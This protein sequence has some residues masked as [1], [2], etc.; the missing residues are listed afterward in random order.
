MRI[1]VIP[2]FA[3]SSLYG[4]ITLV[5]LNYL[6]IARGH[7]QEMKLAPDG[8][9]PDDEEGKTLTIGKGILTG[10]QPTKPNSPTPQPE[11]RD[12]FVLGYYGNLMTYLYRHTA[13]T[14][15]VI[16][17]Y[18]YDWRIRNGPEAD[19]LVLSIVQNV[20]EEDPCCLIAHSN[21][22]LIARWA[23]WRL[24]Q[25]GLQRLVKRII[26]LGTPHFGAYAYFR[27]IA[28]GL[29]SVGYKLFSMNNWTFGS[30]PF[31]KR[32]IIG[33]KV[34][35]PETRRTV[36]SWPGVYELGPVPGTP[37]TEGD[38]NVGGYLNAASYPA[39]FGAQKIA[40][41]YIRNVWHPFLKDLT[42]LPPKSVMITCFGTGFD[43][44]FHL[45]G[46]AAFYESTGYSESPDGDGTVHRLS[47]SLDGYYSPWFSSAHGD[48]P[49]A[50]IQGDRLWSLIKDDVPVPVPPPQ[51]GPAAPLTP[52]LLGRT[53]YP[54]DARILAMLPTVYASNAG[55]NDP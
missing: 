45:N 24:F 44:P 17:P 47:A 28:C 5:W 50:V 41:T 27:E 48:L 55:P 52:M 35:L 22:G 16:H 34:S 3:G 11:P 49:D 8:I 46:K 32:I 37:L 20:K 10:P 19:R 38:P 1:Y 4:P 9:N 43:T 12:G 29:S 2:G 40:L 13:N 26:T 21:G 7:F 39:N 54:P 25:M 42:L 33:N 30:L 15:D 36:L 18:P 31:K 14:P 6:E 53:L 51:T 23:Y